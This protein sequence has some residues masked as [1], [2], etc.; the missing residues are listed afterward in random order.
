MKII[1]VK[2]SALQ[3]T[4]NELSEIVEKLKN[5]FADKDIHLKQVL[6]VIKYK[7]K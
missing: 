4:S 3:L 5:D 7:Q 1:V 2:Y 6:R